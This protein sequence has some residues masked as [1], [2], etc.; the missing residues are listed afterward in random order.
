LEVN[1]Q[2]FFK[3][4]ESLN[5]NGKQ[6]VRVRGES[7]IPLLQEKDLIEIFP[8]NDLSILKRFDVII[9][10]QDNIFMCHYFWK[11]NNHFNKTNEIFL[12]RPLNPINGFDHPIE[13]SQVLGIAKNLKISTWLKFKIIFHH[14]TELKI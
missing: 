12:T 10:W 8:L 1:Q 3:I 7:M 9:F 6:E 11:K 13:S 14:L 5:K 4:K 2:Q